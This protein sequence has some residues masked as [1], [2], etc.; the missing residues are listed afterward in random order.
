MDQIKNIGLMTEF[1]AAKIMSVA[2]LGVGLELQ[3]GLRE[4]AKEQGPLYP[5]HPSTPG[6]CLAK[7]QGWGINCS[8]TGGIGRCGHCGDDFCDN[9]RA[10]SGVYYHTCPGIGY[11]YELP[12]VDTAV[13]EKHINDIKNEMTS[14]DKRNQTNK[15]WYGYFVEAQKVLFT[16]YNE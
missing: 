11:R 5:H 6:R 10:T 14:L 2:L 15:T 9:H 1:L 12:P 13:I 4:L 7:H 8:W 3:I 16:V